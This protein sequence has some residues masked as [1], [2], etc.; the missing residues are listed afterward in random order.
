VVVV[1]VVHAVLHA[2]A[3]GVEDGA[4]QG[5]V[6]HPDTPRTPPPPAHAV[7]MSQI[8][9]LLGANNA[10]QLTDAE[11]DQDNSDLG[12]SVEDMGPDTHE[13]ID[14][15]LRANNMEVHAEDVANNVRTERIL[16][17]IADA[18]KQEKP[19]LDIRP[20]KPIENDLHSS[21]DALFSA[22][23]ATDTAG[24]VE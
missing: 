16:G 15:V 10:D 3:V 4:G 2:M 19:V 6:W 17:E 13:A 7:I 14:M 5:T 11:P 1:V 8:D 20:M 9:D 18:K 12:E 23:I 24:S 21:I 22:N